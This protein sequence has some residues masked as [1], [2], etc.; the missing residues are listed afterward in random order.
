M[1]ELLHEGAA[2]A[3]GVGLG[4]VRGEIKRAADEG[5]VPGADGADGECGRDVRFPHPRWAEQQDAAV[6]L[7]ETRTGQRDEFRF[8]QFRIEGPV[9]IAERFDR[10]DPGL[11]QPAGE[12][13]IRAAHELVL[14]EQLQKL[15]MGERR[16]FS[17]RDGRKPADG[18]V[19]PGRVK[20][21]VS[22]SS[23]DA[24]D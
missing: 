23:V 22:P 4:E 18:G 10:G 21:V 16:R 15:E 11:L 13:P 9:E 1:R 6:G 14:D 19:V 2:R 24:H 8:R 3:R 5:P 12:E 7:H 20:N 17:L